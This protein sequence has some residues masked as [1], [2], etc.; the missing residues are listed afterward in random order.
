MFERLSILK[1]LHPG[2]FLEYELKKKNLSIEQFAIS[3]AERAQTISAIIKGKK[4]LT[5]SL[6]LKAEKALNLEE[7]FLMALQTFYNA[8]LEEDQSRDKKTPD[9]QIIRPALFWDI[10]RSRI[11]WEFHKE[12]VI[13]RIYER[14]DLTEKAEIEK[15]YGKEVVADVLSNLLKRNYL[16][17]TH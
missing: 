8:R 13:K 1:G 5:T 2:F 16:K 14:G 12:F 4:Q 6:S 11:D 10:N 7:G 15:F 9:L 17:I 3:L